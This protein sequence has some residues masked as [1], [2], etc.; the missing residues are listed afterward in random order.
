[1]DC[2]YIS[3]HVPKALEQKLYV[4]ALEERVAALE[5]EL[6]VEGHDGVADDHWERLQPKEDIIDPLSAAIRELSLNACGY[7]VG[8]TTNVS[9]G[10]MLGVALEGE[11]RIS[12][13]PELE[14]D[15]S[16]SS[17]DG[18]TEHYYENTSFSTPFRDP[19][20]NITFLAYM[21]H[22]ASDLPLIYSRRLKRIHE[23]RHG[24]T[25][26]WEKAILH[27]VYAIG[28]RSLELVCMYTCLQIRMSV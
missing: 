7:Y 22:V 4:K 15:D 27:L 13:E 16:A 3:S 24:L 21:E 11:S 18:T 20:A 8:S 17:F 28:G 14:P 23:N 25:N 10:R 1:M 9:L 6:R 12:Y 26:I 5:S 19:S 2:Q